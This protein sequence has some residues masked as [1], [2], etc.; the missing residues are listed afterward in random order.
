MRYTKITWTRED[1]PFSLSKTG[2]ARLGPLSQVR[3]DI[4]YLFFTQDRTANVLVL[5]TLVL[6]LFNLRV[7]S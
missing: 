4:L 6:L 1:L 7:F 5:S 2:Q 3:R